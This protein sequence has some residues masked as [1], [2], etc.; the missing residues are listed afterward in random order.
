MHLPSTIAATYES[1]GIKNVYDWQHEC[2]STAGVSEGES[3]V[4]CAPTSGGKTLIS[5]LIILRSAIYLKKRA[6]FVLPFVSLVVEKEKY[7][8]KIIKKY[9]RFCPKNERLKVKAYH[10]EI[11]GNRIQTNESILICTI[12]KANLLVNTLIIRGFGNSI[13]CVAIDELHTLGDSFNGYL[14]E[15]LIR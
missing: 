8:N 1:L 7:F 12:E 4:Y 3:I 11:T 6:I 10:T 5:E 9:N 15:I 14:L 13:G 2:I